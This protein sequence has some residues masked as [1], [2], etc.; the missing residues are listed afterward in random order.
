MPQGIARFHFLPRP[1]CDGF[2]IANRR[3]GWTQ[4]IPRNASVDIR[5]CSP[6]IDSI[7]VRGE[8]VAFG[9][10]GCMFTSLSYVTVMLDFDCLGV[11]GWRGGR[12]TFC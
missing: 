9:V 8:K 1:R 11:A 3:R 7:L 6:E 2:H 12:E 4:N 10:G 5:A